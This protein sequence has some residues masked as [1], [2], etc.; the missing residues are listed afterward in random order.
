MSA[1]AASE[2]LTELLNRL[3]AIVRCG[4]GRYT[5]LA[6]F[7]GKRPQQIN[8]WLIQR[9]NEPSGSMT[10]QMQVWAASKQIAIA[11]SSRR[12]QL[13]YRTEYKRACDRFP[14]N[15]TK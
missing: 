14:V 7:L 15:E 2:T 3:V 11:G 8:A 4:A 10:M 1:E 6:Q 13:A 9:V 12:L 5:E